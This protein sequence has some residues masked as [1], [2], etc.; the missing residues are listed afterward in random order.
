MS[1]Y[2][3]KRGNYN[4]EMILITFLEISY[5]VRIFFFVLGLKWAFP[6]FPI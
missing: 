4:D 2:D 6:H 3:N 1:T 5:L